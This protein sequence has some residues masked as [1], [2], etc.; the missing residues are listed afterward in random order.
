L[1]SHLVAES[2]RSL[3][4]TPNPRNSATP[5]LR[6]SP[7]DPV[8]RLPGEALCPERFDEAALEKLRRKLGSYSFSALYQQR[9]VP[10]EGGLFKRKWFD[11]VVETPPPNLKW[12]R[13][14][15]LAVSTKTN[16]CYSA[17]AKCAFD[18]EGNLYIADVFRKRIEFPDQKRYIFERIRTERNTEHG[19]EL[20]LHGQ[21]LMQDL[22]REANLRGTAFRGI[23]VEADKVTRALSWASLAEEGKVILVRGPWMQEFLDEVC[24]FPSGATDDQVDAVSIAV[25]MCKERRNFLYTF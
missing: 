5:E 1:Q 14:Y 21:A 8:G 2:G 22:R 3:P 10:A 18:K 11:R 23:K 4:A 13:G 15:D 25:K 17:S 7:Y 24:R 20:A 9:P 12:K 19:I 16:A 6:N